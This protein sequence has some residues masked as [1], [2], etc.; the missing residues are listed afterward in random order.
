M[1]YSSTHITDKN[2]VNNNYAGTNANRTKPAVSVLQKAEPEEELQMKKAVIQKAEPEEELPIQGK[3]VTQRQAPEEELPLQ[4]KLVTQLQAPEEE[5]P[6]QKKA[7]NTG[8]PDNLKSG[9]ENLSG[10]SMDD[11]KVHLNSD[12][13]SQLQAHAYAQGTDIHVAPGQEKHL[14]HE[15]WHVVQQK[16]GR[17][18]PTMQMKEGVAVNDDKSLE[19]EADTMGAKAEEI[20]AVPTQLR[21]LPHN[22]TTDS[23]NDVIPK[24]NSPHEWHAVQQN[25]NPAKT[26]QLF[27]THRGGGNEDENLTPRNR[28]D[29]QG[30][31]K[32][33]STF[34]NIMDAME[35]YRYPNQVIETD[36]LKETTFVENGGTKSSHVSIVPKKNENNA[37]L[38]AW[39]KGQRHGY[40]Q[41]VKNAI[42]S[43]E[44]QK[45][46]EK[47]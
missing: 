3:F 39:S 22:K 37:E 15:A 11:V 1:S 33:L 42:T 43:Q 9:V 8:L 41:D 47:K 5:E 14:P 38:I 20:D 18:Q 2:T 46:E 29:T 21:A 12:K 36:N 10:Y 45:K 32:G 7:N 25:Y 28:I 4:G 27:P 30:D 17:V 16:Q 31:K 24:N 26:H 40:T 6:L 23:A 13:P 44:E 35:K 19:S 34:R